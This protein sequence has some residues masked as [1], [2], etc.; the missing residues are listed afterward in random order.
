MVLTIIP[1]F[2]FGQASTNFN[3][4]DDEYRMLGLKRAKAAFEMAD[5]PDSGYYDGLRTNIALK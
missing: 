1:F 4:R 2:L 5:V 3:Q